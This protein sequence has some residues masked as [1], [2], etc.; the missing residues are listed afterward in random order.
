MKC[1]LKYRWVKLPRT[2]LPAGKGVMGYWVRL[3]ARAA[4]RQGQARYCGYINDVNPG[5]WSGGVV[6][7]KSILGVKNRQKAMTL[8][9]IKNILGDAKKIDLHNSLSHIAKPAM[10]CC[11]FARGFFSHFCFRR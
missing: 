11:Y 2:R 3:A 4:F 6:G 1:L 5:E 10:H 7:L 9:D 8:M